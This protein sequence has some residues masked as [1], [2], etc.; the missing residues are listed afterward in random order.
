VGVGVAFPGNGPED[1]RQDWEKE[2]LE[3]HKKGGVGRKNYL[4]YLW[5]EIPSRI[6]NFRAKRMKVF[7]KPRAQK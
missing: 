1:N 6:A 3:G 2:A 7:L 4:K 5:A